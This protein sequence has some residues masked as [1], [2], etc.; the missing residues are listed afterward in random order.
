VAK[1]LA[2][3]GSIERAVPDDRSMSQSS[4]RVLAGGRSPRDGRSL[5]LEP[6][7]LMEPAIRLRKSPITGLL[8]VVAEAAPGEFR[9]MH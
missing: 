7:A 8:A 6:V 9:I 1:S 2:G 5:R 3:T 4:V